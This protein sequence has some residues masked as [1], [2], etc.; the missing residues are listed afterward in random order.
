MNMGLCLVCV[1][2]GCDCV[3][4]VCLNHFECFTSFS[5]HDHL[6]RMCDL[7]R[8]SLVGRLA[9]IPLVQ[10]ARGL[11]GVLLTH[12]LF[13]LVVVHIFS[14]LVHS[15]PSFASTGEKSWRSS[16]SRNLDFDSEG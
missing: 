3:Y 5:A 16:I 14:M 6:W 1:G 11:D 15:W 8:D 10:E 4:F 13:I 9:M 7:S 12:T 2:L